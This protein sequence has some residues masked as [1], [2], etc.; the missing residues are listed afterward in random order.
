MRI[1]TYINR[2]YISLLL[3][4]RVRS[5]IMCEHDI[6]LHL[7]LH[8][9]IDIQIVCALAPLVGYFYAHS[10][11]C[12]GGGSGGGGPASGLANCVTTRV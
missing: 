10:H 1:H 5:V 11:M 8:V 12:A 9:P 6:N 3:G 4:A 7:H 2:I